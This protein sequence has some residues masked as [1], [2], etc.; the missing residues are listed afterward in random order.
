MSLLNNGDSLEDE[1]ARLA[2]LAKARVALE[3]DIVVYRHQRTSAAHATRTWM[4]F[5]S[6][7]F[8]TMLVVNGSVFILGRVNAAR[9]DG[10]I[11]WQDITVSVASSSPGIILAALG[12]VL[13]AI[14][15]LPN[16]RIEIDD[17][18]TY[19][20]KEELMRFILDNEILDNSDDA[21]EALKD[22]AKEVK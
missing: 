3:R 1:A 7:I 11:Q 2:F 13:I 5:M 15:N 18:S 6:L 8:G 12:C 10:K 21:L 9:T 19:V 20:Q 17:T 14:P 4:R 16:Q 22:R